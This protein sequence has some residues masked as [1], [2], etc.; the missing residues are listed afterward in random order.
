MA[1]FKAP[2]EGAL[3]AP[4][5]DDVITGRGMMSLAE[6]VACGAADAVLKMTFYDGKWRRSVLPTV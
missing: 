1:A 3:A 2:P 6:Q 5:V 4:A